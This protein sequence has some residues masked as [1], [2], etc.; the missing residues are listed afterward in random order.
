MAEIG[1]SNG[2]RMVKG[3]LQS[4]GIQASERRVG[5]VMRELNPESSRSRRE[6]KNRVINPIPY[7]ARYLGDKLHIDQNEKLIMFGVCHVAAKD[8]YSSKIIAHKVF[9]A[10]NSVAIY[11]DFCTSTLESQ[12]IWNTLRVDHGTE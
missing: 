11:K 8:C 6:W 1:P 7:T 3:Y 5:N 9:P 12:G 4:Q 2:V 10:K